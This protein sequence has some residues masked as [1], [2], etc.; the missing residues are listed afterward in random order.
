MDV[1]ILSFSL[2]FQTLMISQQEAAFYNLS[3][4]D[5]NYL[6]H[7]MN[8]ETAMNSRS[9]KYVLYFTRTISLHPLPLN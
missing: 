5:A 8:F 3:A 1:L 4:V 2:Q 7:A 6:D 9:M